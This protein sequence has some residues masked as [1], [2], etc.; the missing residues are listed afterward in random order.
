MKIIAKSLLAC[1]AVAALHSVHAEERV[2]LPSRPGVET[3]FVYQAVAQPAAQVILFEGGNGIPGG[4]N[5][6]FLDTSRKFFSD[7]NI[8]YAMFMPP[9][10]H[11]GGL[12]DTR[13]TKH[14]NYRV[15][16]DHTRDVE[17]IIAWL[18]QKSPVP[19][20]LAGVSAGTISV[21]WL[22]TRVREPVD[23]LVF[24][25]SILR[26]M[27]RVGTLGLQ[28]IHVPTLITH[29]KEDSCE[30]NP[31]FMVQVFTKFLPNETKREI[32]L[33]EGG[34][35]RGSDPCKQ[36]THHTYYGIEREVATAITMFIKDNSQR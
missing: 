32:R 12:Q 5:P 14:S 6:G 3:R 28:N 29:H 4:S 13:D 26:G 9:S 20:W 27:N 17:P 19:I 33:F 34:G 22:G 10:D 7:Q 2:S 11:A 24:S 15:S 8:S 35:V 18:R 30:N 36:G 23:G 25:S 21:G 16:D 1:F 31:P